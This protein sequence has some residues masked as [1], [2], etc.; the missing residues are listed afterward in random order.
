M[1]TILTVC[2]YF[3]FIFISCSR[4]ITQTGKASYYADLF[5]GRKTASGER[6]NN[7]QHTAAHKTL[8]FGTMV[9][10]TNLENGKKVKVRINDRGP[11]VN[12]RVIDL[13]KAAAKKIGMLKDG[14]INVRLKY[15]K[16]KTVHTNSGA[17]AKE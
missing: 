2:L 1:R 7:S 3:S 17:L 16:K 11:Y 12:G 9:T 5:N 14:V 4:G 6:F 13:S 15:K 8:P 10:V